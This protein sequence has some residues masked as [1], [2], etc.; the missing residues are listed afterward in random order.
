[1]HWVLDPR[2]PQARAVAQLWWWMLGV[3]GATW[4]GTVS[5]AFATALRR[6]DETE[7]SPEDAETPPR[8]RR[9]VIA[10]TL[11]TILIL[12]AFLVFDFVVGRSLTNDS[13][14]GLTIDLVGHQWWWEVRYPSPDPSRSFVTANEIHV[15]IGQPIQLRLRAADVI[16][17]FWMPSLN[18]KRDLI[19][20]YM[21][22]VWIQAD[23]AGVY[24]GQCAEFCGLQHA[25]MS[26]VVV[27]ETRD[28]FNGWIAR[29]RAS[30]VMPHDTAMESGERLFESGPCAVC[31]TVAGTPARGGIGPDLTHVASR[32]T[33]G[34]GVLPN[35]LG[36]LEGWLIDASSF[37]P[38]VRM[39][40][41]TMY[42]GGELRDIAMY[43]A[44]LK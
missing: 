16:H 13:S 33:L 31:H 1:M 12:A 7:A 23:S 4:L 14:P 35:N 22:T 24:R 28:A 18:G 25:N 9:G 30:A 8:V 6:P 21:S 41:M 17:S 36:S 2:S 32:L 20:G 27:A 39:P 34:A 11:A 15:P 37:K 19:P 40:R 44:S 26:L 29:Q 10:A 43:V 3:G 42:A 5:V 38:G